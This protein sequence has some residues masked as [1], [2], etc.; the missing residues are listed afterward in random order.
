L[1]LAACGGDTTEPG[2]QRQASDFNG[3][4]SLVEAFADTALG[5]VA[6]CEGT[7]TLVI[8]EADTTFTGT[9]AMLGATTW[10]VNA[11]GTVYDKPG[12]P[13]LYDRV[14]SASTISFRSVHCNYEGGFLGQGSDSIGGTVGCIWVIDAGFAHFAGDWHATK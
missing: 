9:L 2:P 1:V 13:D 3:T 14:V 11:G 4:W 5:V 12:G 7:G 10:C 8:A 6:T